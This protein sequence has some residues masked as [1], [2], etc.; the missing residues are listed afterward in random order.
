M[1]LRL[2]GLA[3][4]LALAVTASAQDE[5]KPTE[6]RREST[7]IEPYTG[8]PIYLPQGEAPPPPTEVESRVVKENFPETDTL[9]FERRIVKFSDD[10]VVSDGP[11]KEYYSN[12]E[13]YVAGE[14]DRGK[15]V[16][17]WVYH[18]PNGTVAKEVT[19]KQGRPDGEVKVF[20]EEG[21]LTARREYAE[22]KRTGVWETY[23]DDGEQK[24]REETYE[25][26]VANGP[27]RTWYTNGQ[28]RQETNFVKGKMEGLAT[29]WTRVG[30]KRA[31]LNFKN[32]L[33]DGAAKVWQT[34]GK[35][36]E[37][38]YDEGQLVSRKG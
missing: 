31:E 13:L 34:D 25:E 14:Y 17:T 24:L 2:A 3:A 32:G 20:N 15:A 26:G 35:V 21:K 19:Y 6:S 38:T 5:P 11:H 37:Q 7:T 30:D 12:G 22:G 36:I 4:S 1:G 18:H 29:E 27:F 23:S 28:I 9:R 8:P 10:T 16:G 33:K